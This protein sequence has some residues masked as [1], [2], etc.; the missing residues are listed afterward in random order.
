MGVGCRM[1]QHCG[2]MRRIKRRAERSWVF[3]CSVVVVIGASSCTFNPDVESGTSETTGTGDSGSE[4]ES[5]SGPSE[6]GGVDEDTGST[7]G[8]SATCGDGIVEGDEECDEGPAND[9]AG[10]CTTSCTNAR[11]GDGLIGPGELCDDGNMVDVDECRNDCTPSCGDGDLDRGEVC[12]DGNYDDSDGCTSACTVPRTCLEILEEVPGVA[13][14]VYQIDPDGPG[15]ELGFQ[16]F[17]DMTTD[18]GG[19]TVIERSGLGESTVGKAFFND[20]PVNASSPMATPHRLGKATMTT[21]R[22]L[23]ADMRID[24]R[25]ED[26][27]L[28]DALNL[29]AG[30]GGPDNCDNWT[31]I[32]YKEAQLK[33]NLLLNRKICTWHLGSTEGCAGVWHIDEHA[34]EFYCGMSDYPWA[35]EPITSNSA[36]TFSTDTSTTD[37]LEPIHDCHVDGAERWVLLR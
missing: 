20:V 5:D 35:G 1:Q 15:G 36:D 23:S 8:G 16:V 37:L 13:D 27:L 22:Q 11:C 34:Q 9:D 26:Y 18:S 6:T 3:S 19:W 2:T 24:C 25:G 31:K 28:T 33:G 12:D 4:G 14:G 30:E 32:L 29:F 10:A 17:C 7:D 21:L